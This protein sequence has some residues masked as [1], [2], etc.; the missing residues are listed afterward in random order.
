[1]PDF[2]LETARALAAESVRSIE[3]AARQVIAI[4]SLA[5]A[6]YFAAVSFGG[7]RAAAALYTAG[8]RAIIALALVSPLLCWVISLFFAMRVFKPETYQ[9]NLDAPDQ[10]E[11][12]VREVVGYKR[13]QLQSAYWF[14]VLGFAPLIAN[15]LLVFL[16]F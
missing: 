13:R 15:A 7:A 1:M 3:E 6:V 4:A 12:F 2:W 11:S 5:Q 8:E 9:T 10:A 16:V 14:L